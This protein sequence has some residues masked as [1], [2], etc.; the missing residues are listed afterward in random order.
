MKM[1]VCVKCRQTEPAHKRD[2][3]GTC[4]QFKR[5]CLC[6]DPENCVEVPLET[7][8]VCQRLRRTDTP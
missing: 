1:P 7:S 6:A 3:I 4:E 8:F 2:D 5:W